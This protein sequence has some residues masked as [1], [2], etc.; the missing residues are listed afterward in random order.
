MTTERLQFGS[1]TADIT[2]DRPVFLGGYGIGPVRKC[3]GI[4]SRLYVRAAAISLGDSTLAIAAIDTHGLLRAYRHAPGH[5]EIS[6]AAKSERP[7]IEGILA[8]STH[9]HSAPD[10]TG[11]WGGLPLPEYERIAEGVVAAI[12]DAIDA[13]EPATFSLGSV[14]CPD[15]LRNQCGY[16][17]HDTLD[18]SLT[19]ISATN[20]RGKALGRIIHFSAHATVASGHEVSSDWYGAIASRLDESLSGTSLVLPGAIGRTQPAIRGDGS[21]RAVTN[22]ASRV[23]DKAV[24]AIDSSAP[25]L[26][27]GIGFATEPVKLRISNPLLKG[28]SRLIKRDEPVNETAACVARIGPVLLAGFPGEVYPN[29]G[30]AM[31]RETPDSTILPVSLT[32]DQVGYLIYP[33]NSYGRILRDA[34]KNDNSYFCPSPRAGETLLGSALRMIRGFDELT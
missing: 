3:T 15:L 30:D 27:D 20:E 4:A 10:S 25:L 1:A 24:E 5:R 19:V 31:R 12:T 23:F 9:S 29:I 22:Y 2:P 33:A 8:A 13:S 21:Q 6:A 28:I 11:V 18:D 32:G 17:P 26:I 16:P 7:Q 34:Y 14:R